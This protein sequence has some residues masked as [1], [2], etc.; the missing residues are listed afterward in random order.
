MVTLIL[1]IL[2]MKSV[3]SHLNERAARKPVEHLIRTVSNFTYG[4]AFTSTILVAT[5]G[6]MLMPFGSAFVVYNNGIDT[7]YLTLIYGVTGVVAMIAAPAIGKLADSLGKY[8]VFCLCSVVM[9]AAVVIHSNLGTTSLWIVIILSIGAFIG[10]AGRMVSS[11]ALL[12][13]VPVPSDRGAFMS[14]NSSVNMMSG[15]IASLIAGA[16]VHQTSTN[17]LI[18]YDLLAYVVAG[19][20]II[21]VVIMY[22][23][24]QMVKNRHTA[25]DS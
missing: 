17:Q 18:N 14:I 11:S 21:T 19:A 6:F 4:K 7:K 22:F 12:T 3:D 24:D 2:Y 16:I 9:V 13:A 10:Y 23:I 25:T 8:A 1:I 15:G 5:A 20:T